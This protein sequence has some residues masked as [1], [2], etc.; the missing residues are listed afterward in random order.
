MSA[1]PHRAG[2]VAIVGRPN[3]GKSTLLNALVGQKVSI[4]SRKAQTTRRRIVGILTRED[5]QVVFVDTPGFPARRDTALNRLMNRSVIAGLHDVN[6]VL[7]VLDGMKA[8]RRE[9]ELREAVPAAVPVV[10]AINKIDR[11]RN[12][13]ELLPFM[14]KIAQQLDCSRIVPVSASRG[15]GLDELVSVTAA[16]MPEGPALYA[17]DEITRS[18]ERFLAAELI[19]EKVFRT[20][21][22]ELPYAT[23]VDIARFETRGGV[24]RIYAEILV[25]KESQ[26][27]ILI[28]RN[29]EKLKAIA[30]RSRED[31]E[32]LFGGKVFLD[33]WV[34]VR[35]GWADDARA[36]RRLGYEEQ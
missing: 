23:A 8:D 4:T 26:K 34:K 7:L 21:G 13:S 32:R 36:L 30:S 5:V 11:I 6:A 28:G 12:K 27:P 17:D 14:R 15:M 10:V 16:L 9:V 35:R 2:Y 18:S 1:S 3:A 19:R 25:D 20:M 33:V 31:M 29:G 22:D 24:R